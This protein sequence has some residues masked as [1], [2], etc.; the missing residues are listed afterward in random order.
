MVEKGNSLFNIQYKRRGTFHKTTGRFLVGARR[1]KRKEKLDYENT[2]NH[3][4]SSVRVHTHITGVF[5][6]SAVTSVITP[7]IKHYISVFIIH[8]S[9]NYQYYS[10]NRQDDIGKREF[11]RRFFSEIILHFPA[12]SHTPLFSPQV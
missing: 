3:R 12:L 5:Y 7:F 4:L 2:C 10:Q 6:V 1:W 8:F 11:S 9:I